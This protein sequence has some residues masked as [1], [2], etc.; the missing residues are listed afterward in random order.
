MQQIFN[1]IYPVGSIYMS[2]TLTTEEQV[3]AIFGGTWEKIKDRFLLASGD[4]YINGTAGGEATHTLTV[5]E[6]P[7]HS[8]TMNM[9]WSTSVANYYWQP[10]LSAEAGE[11]KTSPIGDPIQA[12]GGSQPH[13]NMPPY[14]VVNVFKRLTLGGG[15]KLI[16]ASI[17]LTL[18]RSKAIC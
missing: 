10:P 13:N 7:S 3:K 4:S 11:T 1:L 14:L 8:H 17:I 6:M 15:L 16:F 5:D 12:A 2:T 18:K 9:R